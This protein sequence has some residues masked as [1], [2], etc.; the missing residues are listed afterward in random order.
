MFFFK[1]ANLQNLLETILYK[2]LKRKHKKKLGITSHF[3]KTINITPSSNK[4]KC[5]YSETKMFTY[6]FFP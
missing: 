1:T 5:Y 4:T 3:Y 6:K 2:L